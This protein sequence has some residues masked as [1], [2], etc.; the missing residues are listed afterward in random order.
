[1]LVLAVL[2]AGPDGNAT[3]GVRRTSEEIAPGLVLERLRFTRGPIRAFVLKLHLGKGLVP[4]VALGSRLLPVYG[5]TVPEITLANDAIAA[6][7]GD[8]GGFRPAHAFA[9]DGQL[10][11]TPIRR[12]SVV[13]FG[14]SGDRVF[15]GRPRVRVSARRADGTHIRIDL[16]NAGSPTRNE[17]T[18]YTRTG[19][20]LE[21]PPPRACSVRL[22]PAR[23]TRWSR[24]RTHLRTAM[25]VNEFGCSKEPMPLDSGIVLSARRGTNAE[26]WMR[27][28]SLDERLMLSWTSGW[29]GVVDVQGGFP[30]LVMN[31]RVNVRDRCRSDFCRRQPRT[32]IGATKGCFDDVAGSC[33]VQYV[34]VDGR[35]AGW[36]A[37]LRLLDF[38]RLF[39]RLGAW[40][41][42]NLDGGGSS[43]MVVRGKVVNRPAE[44]LRAVPSAFLILAGPDPGE[45]DVAEPA[46]FSSAWIETIVRA[47]S[48]LWS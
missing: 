43:T 34:V 8:F 30:L 3:V 21:A 32:G 35:R 47:L 11:Q 20:V 36:S 27:G 44:G 17:L 42:L 26:A 15:M 37:G 6:I 29:P 19:G 23:G 38:A 14:L 48:A 2:T 12:G 45:R 4:D 46:G 10:L 31:G 1:M 33:V 28:L 18:G 40:R 39:R 22:L 41:A 13:G 7:N 9:Q 24:D 16:W 5:R 25:T